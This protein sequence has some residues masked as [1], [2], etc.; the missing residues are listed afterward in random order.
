MTETEG[1]VFAPGDAVLTAQPGHS[2]DYMTGTSLSAAHVSGVVALMLEANP[3]VDVVAASTMLADSI[4]SSEDGA[5]IDACAA[6]NSAAGST[7]CR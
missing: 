6:V 2:Y 7:R 1:G 4:R 3:D 5:S